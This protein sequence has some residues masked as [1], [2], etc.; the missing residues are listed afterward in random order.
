MFQEFNRLRNIDMKCVGRDTKYISVNKF[1][2]G[3][4]LL[5]F[6]SSLL[7]TSCNLKNAENRTSK[8]K[9]KKSYDSVADMKLCINEDSIECVQACLKNSCLDNIELGEL[10]NEI[11]VHDRLDI[12]T[13]LINSNEIQLNQ[14]TKHDEH[15]LHFAV[16]W[17]SVSILE[18]LI[19]NRVDLNM[20]SNNQT[21]ILYAYSFGFPTYQTLK[22]LIDAGADINLSNKIGFTPLHYAAKKSD[23]ASVKILVDSRADVNARTTQAVTPLMYATCRKPKNGQFQM[24]EYLIRHGAEI[25][26]IDNNWQ[27][28]MHYFATCEK[29]NEILDERVVELLL[30]QG[31]DLNTRDQSGYGQTPYDI[32]V[33]ANSIKLIECFKKYGIPNDADNSQ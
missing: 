9:T 22:L 19:K 3:C 28:A 31:N 26:L 1:L 8:E 6:A 18:Y 32:A 24:M 29:D 14:M 25:D 15:I 4:V 33:K 21:P 17:N 2:I 16:K 20:E 10:F 30:S 12:Y 5:V 7:F 11:A 23:I 13:Y 27:N